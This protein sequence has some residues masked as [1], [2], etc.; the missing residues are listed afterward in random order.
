MTKSLSSVHKEFFEQLGKKLNIK[1]LDEWYKY[2][3]NAVT[4]EGGK[5]I[6][7]FYAGG[8]VSREGNILAKISIYLVGFLKALATAYPEKRWH[9]WKFTDRTPR[10]FWEETKNQV[11]D[12]CYVTFR[13]LFLISCKKIYSLRA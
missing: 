10:N 5:S 11:P 8:V 4:R 6:L 3:I 2:G 9:P 1:D 7:R 12:L 13:E